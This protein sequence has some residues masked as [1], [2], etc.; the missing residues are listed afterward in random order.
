MARISEVKPKKRP[1][2]NNGCGNS[3]RLCPATVSWGLTAN[4]EL[5]IEAEERELQKR[6][7]E[8]S[9]DEGRRATAY[10]QAFQAARAG[11]TSTAIKLVEEYGLDV[12]SPEKAPKPTAKKTDKSTNFQS[13]LHAACRTSDEGLII[14][15]LDRGMISLCSRVSSLSSMTCRCHYRRS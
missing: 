4:A 15:L 6:A 7:T 13:L 3:V 2:M 10:Q 8:K 12:N 14:F 9:K 11:K 5:E 1:S